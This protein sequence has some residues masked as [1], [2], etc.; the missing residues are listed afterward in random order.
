MLFNSPVF[1]IYFLPITLI[2]YYTIGHFCRGHAAFLWLTLASLFFYAWWNPIFLPFLLA[3]MAVNYLIGRQL[4]RRPS[5]SLLIAGVTANLLLLGYFK[6]SGFMVSLADSAF[7]LHVAM[8]AILLPLA[9]S[10]Y[11]FQQIAYLSDADDGLAVDH[12]FLNYSLFI[13]FF[14]HLIAGPITH[15]REMLP[16]FEDKATLRP[17]TD[18]L[19]IGLTI[20]LIGMMKKVLIAD[21]LSTFAGPVFGAAATGTPLT[22]LEAWGGALSYALQ[23]YFDF[24]GYTDMA[25]GI[26]LMFGIRL[27]LNFNSPYKAHNIIEFWSRW[28][29]TL[30]RFLTTYVYNPL[31]VR[32]MRY[33]VAH[34]LPVPRHGRYTLGAFAMVVAIPTIATMFLSGLWH[35]AGWQFI[36][37]GMLHG[38]Y[39]VINHAWRTIR[40]RI[41]DKK[42]ETLLG[43]AASVLLTFL[44][45]VVANVFFR[46]NDIPAAMAVLSGMIGNHGFVV[47]QSINGARATHWLVVLLHLPVGSAGMFD[48]SALRWLTFLLPVVWFLPNTQQWMLTSKTALA[49]PAIPSWLQVQGWLPR[50]FPVVWKP[51]LVC[52]TSIGFVAFVALTKALSRAPTEFLYFRF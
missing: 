18:M 30:T 43:H 51:D 39:L 25:I 42:G 1:L 48:L 23:L 35:G 9:I 21:P 26:G 8:P 22:M 32:M 14:P 12:D 33:R 10:F 36:L 4:S 19:A 28:H 3:S 37:F 16:Q 6:Y 2:G 24:S 15:H 45:V 13:T 49:P 11:T 34:R 27:P 31:V 17:R 7:G 52:G 29:M 46:S 5:R 50:F 20:F 47:D 40:I 41:G 44:C 38:T